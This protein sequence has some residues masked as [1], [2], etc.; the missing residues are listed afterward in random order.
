MIL[1]TFS[2]PSPGRVRLAF[3][4][5]VGK[6]DAGDTVYD[7]G[8]RGWGGDDHCLSN[9]LGDEKPRFYLTARQTAQILAAP[10][11]QH[12]FGGCVCCQHGPVKWLCLRVSVCQDVFCGLA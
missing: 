4:S 6:D 1:H 3:G 2:C 9:S 7:W 5:T 12:S 11:A 8:R 10:W